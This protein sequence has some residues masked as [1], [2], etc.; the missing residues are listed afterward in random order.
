MFLL[1]YQKAI[2]YGAKNSY[3][4]Q[5]PNSI[6]NISKKPNPRVCNKFKFENFPPL[7][8]IQVH[9]WNSWV[10]CETERREE[11]E[12]TKIYWIISLL[13]YVS[14]IPHHFYYRNMSSLSGCGSQCKWKVYYALYKSTILCFDHC[15]MIHIKWV[16]RYEHINNML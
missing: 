2:N 13:S 16:Q 9:I 5:D 3:W 14:I 8:L 7:S 10:F 15:I 1:S 11:E 12:S 6:D 4:Q